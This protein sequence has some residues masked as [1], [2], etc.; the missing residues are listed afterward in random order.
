[1]IK[2]RSESSNL[3]VFL[4]A[5]SN[6]S[7]A[8]GLV[9]HSAAPSAAPIFRSSAVEAMITGNTGGF[10]RGSEVVQSFPSALSCQVHVEKNQIGPMISGLMKCVRAGRSDASGEPFARSRCAASSRQAA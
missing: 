4:T 2:T 6:D 8:S 7:L 3:R 10:R 5:L 1:M 9:K